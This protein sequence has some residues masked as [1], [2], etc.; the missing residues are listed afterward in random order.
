M[1]IPSPGVHIITAP[2]PPLCLHPDDLPLW[3]LIERLAWAIADQE[4][5]PLRAIEPKRRPLADGAVGLCYTW[6]NRIAILVRYKDRAGDGGAWWKAPRPWD[7]VVLTVAHEL[8][9]LRHPNHGSEFK[10]LTDYLHKRAKNW[11][12]YQDYL[13]ARGSSGYFQE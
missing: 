8:A 10:Q 6:E 4:G 1:G 12:K 7:D 2:L 5:L 11:L 3:R 13:M 9:H